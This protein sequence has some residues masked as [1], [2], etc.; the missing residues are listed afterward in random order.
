M[1]RGLPPKSKRRFRLAP[2]VALQ[3]TGSMTILA[4]IDLSP[5]SIDAAKAAVRL[6]RVLGDR[7]LLLRVV[8]PVSAFYPEL[9]LAGAP[10]LDDAIRKANVEALEN[11]HSALESEDLDVEMDVVAGR[12]A[13]AIVETARKIDA[14]LIVMGTHGRGAAARL[15]LG[16]I[17]QKTILHTTCAV[18]VVRQGSQPFAGWGS[19]APPLRVMAGID[20][21]PGGGQILKWLQ[22]LRA[23][24]PVAITLLHQYW[25]AREYARL[26]LQGPR[27]VVATDAEVVAILDRELRAELASSGP[28]GVAPGAEQGVELRIAAVRG[29]VGEQLAIDAEADHADLIAVVTTQ[30]HGWDRLTS[31]SIAISALTA[32]KLPVLAIPTPGQP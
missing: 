1:I 20:H 30:P 11:V 9:L 22:P 12:P 3:Y 7:L 29:P 4:A 21:G 14:R 15:L 24:G 8:E 16:S 6:A 32:S 13:E 19:G 23:A 5:S 27:D 28:A 2:A 10:D 18:L 25:P 17:T 31:G 26:G